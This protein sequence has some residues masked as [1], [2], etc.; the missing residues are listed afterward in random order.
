MDAFEVRM[1]FVQALRKLTSRHQDVFKL[2]SL[3]LKHGPKCGDD[4][5]DCLFEECERAS[6]NSRINMFYALDSLL[7]ASAALSFPLYLTLVKR[8]LQKLVDLVVPATLDGLLNLMSTE[9]VLKTWK[10]RRIIESSIIEHVEQ[11]LKL[12]K[13]I[14]HEQSSHSSTTFSE[15][16]TKI[17]IDD[18][19]ERHKR[20]RERIWV[21]PPPPSL[22]PHSHSSIIGPHLSTSTSTSHTHAN[23][24]TLGSTSW[25]NSPSSPSELDSIRLRNSLAG[26]ETK[27]GQGEE[28]PVGPPFEE[29]EEARLGRLMQPSVVIEF[30][31]MYSALDEELSERKAD[32]MKGKKR[33]RVGGGGDGEYED[34]DDGVARL[35]D[36]KMEREMKFELEVEDWESMRGERGRCFV[37]EV[38]DEEERGSGL[39]VGT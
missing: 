22:L 34:G 27:E 39:Q 16:D 14:V 25:S 18:D 8:D 15:R 33:K 11:N 19:R 4:L 21:L 31:Q 36:G 38:E 35:D 32:D 24:P 29:S 2:V 1:Q 7:D 17:R 20:L 10:T 26:K 30:D 23:T 12:R 28:K 3:A 37:R 9:Q 5:W 6:L 13:Q